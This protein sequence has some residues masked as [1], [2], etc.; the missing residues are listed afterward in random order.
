EP[1]RSGSH[2][3]PS[4]DGIAWR[5]ANAGPRSRC[6]SSPAQ[7][8]AGQ[9]GGKSCPRQD[10][11]RSGLRRPRGDHGPACSRHWSSTAF[12]RREDGA[13][14]E[15]PLQQLLP[16]PGLLIA[17]DGPVIVQQRT[18]V[19]QASRVIQQLAERIARTLQGS[20]EIEGSRLLELQG[21]DGDDGLREA[22]V[23]E[24]VGM[25]AAPSFLPTSV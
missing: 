19:R 20:V 12:A 18:I 4:Q 14:C 2:D 16:W 8:L 22:P 7:Y 17:G 23:G 10:A 25:G 3:K 15:S 24:A 6:A 13:L 9:A 5:P 21:A 11:R 1:F